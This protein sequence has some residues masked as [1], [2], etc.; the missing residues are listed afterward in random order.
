DTFPNGKVNEVELQPGDRHVVELG[1]GGGYGDPLDRPV[2]RVVADVR[3]GYV[4]ETSA[5]ARYGVAVWTAA[6]G[7][8]EVDAAATAALR[9]GGTDRPAR[10]SA[11]EVRGEGARAQ[12]PDG[13]PAGSSGADGS[14]RA[15]ARAAGRAVGT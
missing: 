10:R 11:G 6:D 1:G 13:A 12:A 2:E 9:A 15:S 3:A 4:T 7:S 8:V 14:A 5:R